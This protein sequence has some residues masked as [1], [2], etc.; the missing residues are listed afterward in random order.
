[1]LIYNTLPQKQVV[2]VFGK[3][4]EFSP[5]QIKL[6][7]NEGVG[8]HLIMQKA[9]MG[10]VEVPDMCV[11]TPDTEEAKAAKSEARS[12]GIQNRIT[13]L[14]G[15]IHNL[16]VSL[17]RD[18]EQANIKGDPLSYASNGELAAYKELKELKKFTADEG[19]ARADEIKKL[20]EE[21]N[22]DTDSADAS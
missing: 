7:H 6:I 13:W 15:I 5:N 10:F 22:G 9:Y 3:Y 1:M 14:R 4:F 12:R 16:E 11:E 2:T 17:K 8:A 18:L 19:A 21:L 20:K